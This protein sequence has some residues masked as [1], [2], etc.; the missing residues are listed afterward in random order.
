MYD[1]L[2]NLYIVSFIALLLQFAGLYEP[3]AVLLGITLLYL[4]IAD[5]FM[6]DELDRLRRMYSFSYKRRPDT[7]AAFVAMT[8][9]IGLLHL[10]QGVH[11]NRFLWRWAFW[12]QLIGTLAALYLFLHQYLPSPGGGSRRHLRSIR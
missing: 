5:L 4:A 3:F 2:R 1:I 8:A 7:T 6:P 10:A 9:S 12:L 11:M